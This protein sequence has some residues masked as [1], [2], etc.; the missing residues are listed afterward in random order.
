MGLN[1]QAEEPLQMSVAHPLGRPR[2]P[3]GEEVEH[4]PNS[5]HHRHTQTRQI[6][7]YP[8]LL[9][10]GAIGYEQDVQR[11]GSQYACDHLVVILD[12]S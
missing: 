6:A 5:D 3:A 9:S 8:F 4:A 11:A 12:P 7:G 10:R 1:Y 2:H